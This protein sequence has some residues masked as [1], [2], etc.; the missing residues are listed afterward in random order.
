[1]ATVY[2]S[3]PIVQLIRIGVDASNF[4]NMFCCVY[5]LV[6]AYSCSLKLLWGVGMGRM[7]ELWMGPRECGEGRRHADRKGDGMRRTSYPRCMCDCTNDMTLQ[8]V[9]PEK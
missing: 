6:W 5:E 3:L 1:M 7:E 2:L 4:C 9:Q 8:C